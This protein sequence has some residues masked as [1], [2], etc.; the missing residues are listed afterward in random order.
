MI[1]SSKTGKTAKTAIITPLVLV[2]AILVLCMNPVRAETETQKKALFIPTSAWLVG[3]SSVGVKAGQSTGGLPCVMVNQYDNGFLFRFS[4]GG[5]KLRAVA[6]DF[7]QRAFKVGKRYDVGLT[8]APDFKHTLSALAFNEVTLILNTQEL[9]GF[10]DVLKQGKQMDLKIGKKDLSF[11]LL[12]MADG[13]QRIEACYNPTKQKP[14]AR[15]ASS[16][17]SQGKLIPLPNEKTVTPVAQKQAAAP[18]QAVGT[19]LDQAARALNDIAPAAGPSVTAG[20]VIAANPRDIM[21]SHEPTVK[22]DA[23]YSATIRKRWR[24]MRGA[25][26]REVLDVWATHS[27]T[28]LIWMAGQD[29]SVHR[30]L[31]LQGTFSTAVLSI[32]E[33]FNEEKI[34]PVGRMYR[35]PQTGGMVLLIELDRAL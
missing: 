22:K 21:V 7:R 29:F 5:Q 13:L 19:L 28:K 15:Q 34:R 26:L 23:A 17:P 35:D 8:I 20:S 33:Q 1:F 10:Y 6:I 2:A 3:P 9:E 14:S 24:T 18:T 31:S 25:N 27:N 11:S 4:G 32:L 16:V 12:G 30:S